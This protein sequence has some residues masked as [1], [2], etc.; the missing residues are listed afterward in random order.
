VSIASPLT[1]PSPFPRRVGIRIFTFEASSGFT[2]VTARWIAQPPK[3]A[4]VTRLRPGRLPR[5]AAR[6][7]PDQSTTLWV[8][9]S[10]TGDARRRGAPGNSGA[11]GTTPS[12]APG[13][14]GEVSDWGAYRVRFNNLEYEPPASVN[15]KFSRSLCAERALEGGGRLLWITLSRASDCHKYE[16]TLGVALHFGSEGRT[17]AEKLNKNKDQVGRETLQLFKLSLRYGHVPQ[18]RKRPILAS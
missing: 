7:L 6:Q 15:A 9:P 10:S 4:F 18:T 11:R 14:F 1:R 2:R 17:F 5:Q 3:A 12:A 16:I 8:E 13:N